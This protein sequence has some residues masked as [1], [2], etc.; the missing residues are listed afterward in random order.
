VVCER[1][2]SCVSPPDGIDQQ[3]FLDIDTG[4]DRRQGTV[5][6]NLYERSQKVQDGGGDRRRWR[7]LRGLVVASE[8]QET[9]LDSWR[10]IEQLSPLLGGTRCSRPYW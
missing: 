9:P 3:A 7:G 4:S 6:V 1:E 5:A 2:T 10:N 8:K